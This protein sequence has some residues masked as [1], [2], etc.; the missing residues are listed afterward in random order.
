VIGQ[1][2]VGL[3]RFRCLD[4]HCPVM[5]F[6]VR[7]PD[8]AGKYQCESKQQMLSTSIPYSSCLSDVNRLGHGVDAPAGKS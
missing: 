4:I 7:T 2:I 5:G 6:Q 3:A 1:I 8:A